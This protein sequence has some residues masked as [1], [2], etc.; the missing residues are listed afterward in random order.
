ML[1][2]L[3]IIALT[4]AGCGTSKEEKEKGKAYVNQYKGQ[5][6][7]YVKGTY[8]NGSKIISMR[9]C[10]TT[11]HDT[12]WFGFKNY[13]NGSVE[14]EVKSGGQRFGV[15]YVSNTNTYYTD[16]NENE[17]KESFR[18]YVINA[19]GTDKIIL[20]KLKYGIDP[21]YYSYFNYVDN[22][23]T[24]F[25]Q[26]YD[27]K[28]IVQ[29]ECY[30]K[31]TDVNQLK[32]SDTFNYLENVIV[33]GSNGYGQMG[34]VFVNIK[35]ERKIDKK[36]WNKIKYVNYFDFGYVTVNGRIY[37]ILTSDYSKKNPNNTY[38]IRY[39]RNTSE[40]LISLVY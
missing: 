20:V 16:K 28:N 22:S 9:P 25:E 36:E 32:E 40:K 11:K 4:C 3:C 29:I 21:I 27:N 38:C 2:L 7:E 18:K 10:Y 6:T 26:L 30:L 37:T 24:S 8:G 39:D 23:I 33:K 35:D 12:V 34:V 13:A 31:D 1:L 19:M 14:T 5:I 15:L 17:I